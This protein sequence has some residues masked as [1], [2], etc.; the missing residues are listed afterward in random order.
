V[1][2]N[3][4]IAVVQ[5]ADQVRRRVAE[6]DSAATVV[7]LPKE[8]SQPLLILGTEIRRRVTGETGCVRQGLVGRVKIDQVPRPCQLQ[9][10]LKVIHQERDVLEGISDSPQVLNVAY[11]RIAMPAHGNVELAPTVYAVQAI[12]AGVVEEDE[13]SCTLHIAPLRVSRL[14]VPVAYFVIVVG[15]EFAVFMGF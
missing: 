8:D 9:T 2:G 6:H 12:V 4:L 15:D 3:L 10:A 14:A 1:H 5:F 11:S 13:P 7:Q